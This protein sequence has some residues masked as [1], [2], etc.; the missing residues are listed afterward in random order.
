MF[1]WLQGRRD[2]R[3]KAGEIYGAVVAQS[4]NPSFYLAFGVPDALVGRY[5]MIA[6]HMSLVLDRLAAADIGDEELRRALVERFVTDMDDAMRELGVGDMSVPRNVKKAAAGL[7]ERGVAYRDSVR[8]QMARS[9][10]EN[11]HGDALEAALSQ[12]VYA[13]P[14]ASQ[15]SNP[16]PQIVPADAGRH[17]NSLG[18]YVRHL[19]DH[20]ASIPGTVLREGHISFP[21]VVAGDGPAQSE[22]EGSIR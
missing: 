3:R 9:D 20:L 15:A 12:Y 8:G 6:L 2:D 14:P 1:D 17:I 21:V 22:K 18:R 11:A 16:S 19:A 13:A 5:E 10:M 4:R 7:Y